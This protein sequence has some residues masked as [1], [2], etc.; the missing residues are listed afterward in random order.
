P[1][2][3]RQ[4]FTEDAQ[5]LARKTEQPAQLPIPFLDD[6]HSLPSAAGIALGIDRLV[7]LLTNA[8]TIDQVVSFT[9]ED[10]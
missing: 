6:L 3:Q 1:L 7:M 2:E 5:I 4:R 9:P 8:Q 10:L